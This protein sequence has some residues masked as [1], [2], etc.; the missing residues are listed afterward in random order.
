MCWV[1]EGFKKISH[2][3]A[4][5]E[6]GDNGDAPTCP[7]CG[8]TIGLHEWVGKPVVRIAGLEGPF[9]DLLF[10]SGCG[11]SIVASDRFLKCYREIN[12]LGLQTFDRVE[13]RSSKSLA[14]RLSHLAFYRSTPIRFGQVDDE[15]SGIERQSLQG[16][17]AC[18]SG[19][20]AIKNGIHLLQPCP[21]DIWIPFNLN[22]VMGSD[23]LVEALT[24]SN[25]VLP[26]LE[27]CK[28]NKYD[29]YL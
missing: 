17:R 3:D 21:Y 4:L 10:P 20:R 8:N 1:L 24:A 23:R 26:T 2:A 28:D 18:G 27:R 29:Y 25:L 19:V 12:G 7:N 5:T 22:Q 15:K 16:C 6:D 9:D 13:M 14:S 11:D